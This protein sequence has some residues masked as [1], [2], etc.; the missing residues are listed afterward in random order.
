MGVISSRYSEALF[1]L[2]V[3]NNAVQEY[4]DSLQVIKDVFNQHSEICEILRH[5]EI[6]LSE[7]VSLVESTFANI[8]K[9]VLIFLLVIVEKNRIREIFN[10]IKDYEIFYNAHLNIEVATVYTVVELTETQI[11]KLEEKLCIKLDKKIKVV[12]IIDESILGGMRIVVHNN[13][14]ESSIKSKFKDL[15]E[16]LHK[17]Q[18]T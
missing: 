15:E 16:Q 9:M 18:L 10:M 17:I 11:T 13:V 5:P 3:E 7:K 8:D 2:A 1:D 6:L 4:F 14:I 12:N